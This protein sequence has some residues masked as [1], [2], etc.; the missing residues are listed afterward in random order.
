MSDEPLKFPDEFLK[1]TLPDF[2][3]PSGIEYRG[4]Y[5]LNFPLVDNHFDVWYYNEDKYSGP[6]WSVATT[7][8][9]RSERGAQAWIDL[10]IREKARTKA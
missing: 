7:K 5:I 2:L 1:P 4:H 10:L 9:C 8:P 6:G 3:K